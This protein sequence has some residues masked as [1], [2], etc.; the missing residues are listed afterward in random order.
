M[1]KSALA[2]LVAGSLILLN[3]LSIGL[4][5]RLDLTRDKAFTLS[6]ATKEVVGNLENPV[7]ISAYFSADM[8]PPHSD[9]ARYLKDLLEEYR[10]ASHGNLSFEF[11]DPRSQ[12]SEEDKEK[13]KDVKQDMFGR[14]VR[15]KTKVEIDLEADKVTPQPIA[16]F[17]NDKRETMLVY[18]AIVVRYG[19][20]KESI[21][22]IDNIETAES[23]ITTIIR[24]LVRK[25]VP[26][27]GV[28][29]GHGEPTVEQD[30]ARIA[31]A[32]ERDYTLKAVTLSS[33]G[34]TAV[35]DDVDSLLVV[36]PQQP[37]SP[38]ELNA[39]DAFIMKGK[40][41]AFFLDRNSVDFRS[42]SPTPNTQNVD[43]LVSSY[44]IEL[45]QQV[46]GDVECAELQMQEQRGFLT[47]R[48]PV[49]YPFIPM[50]RALEGA[51]AMAKGVGEIAVP[52][53][54]PVYP[55]SDLA[56]V[57]VTALAKSSA[58]SWLEEPTQENLNP[59]RDW[60][61]AE[62]SFTGP[63]TLMAQA[64]GTLPSFAT[65]G[66]TSSAEARVIVAGSA[67]LL[68]EQVANPKLVL[69]MMDW[70]NVDPKLLEMRT[71]GT[72]EARFDAN[73]TDATR[74][75][76]KWGNVVGV[77]LLLVLLGIIRWRLREARRNGLLAATAAATTST[78]TTTTTTTSTGGAQ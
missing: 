32:I 63:Y 68:N 78:P 8:P 77:P 1:Q 43:Q 24:R 2:L 52:F 11:L 60:G 35:P 42:F 74:N 31:K 36:G 17:A 69:N 28:V 72:S 12:E 29:Q 3:I 19:E 37:Y 71:R 26:V 56:G 75:G 54:V 27:V 47:L 70:L 62:V 13:R 10:A 55:K 15:E 76:I 65:Q 51:S 6:G 23:D 22:Y 7:T 18:K 5:T 53:A 61:S 57:E 73:L 46:V 45:G 48:V 67:T 64:K 38:D 50:P 33:D 14:L 30:L 20:E 39:I 9:H 59:K 58:K 66:Q 44:G 16:T 21:P 49:K 40:S 34:K 4:F 25:K 41:A